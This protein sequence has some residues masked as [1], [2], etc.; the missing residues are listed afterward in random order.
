MHHPAVRTFPPGRTSRIVFAAIIVVLA[1]GLGAAWSYVAQRQ[2]A[3]A[4]T[5]N[6]I[7]EVDR[8]GAVF[9][10]VRARTQ[11]S[12]RAQCRLLVED[13]RLKSTLAT[14][15]MD[16]ATVA[17]ILGDLGKQRGS[18]F[19][20]VLNPEGH[21]FAEWGADELRGL[22]LS[23]SAVIKNAK[24]ASEAVTGSWVIG[25]TIIDLGAMTIRLD[26]QVIAFL[27]VGQQVDAELAKTL[28][29]A[30]GDG[31]AVVVG[32]EVTLL[33]DPA[34]RPVVE[35]LARDSGTFG[36][37]PVD[38]AHVGAMLDLEETAQSHPRLAVVRPLEPTAQQFALLGWLLWLPPVLVLIALMLAMSRRT[39]WTAG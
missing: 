22:D 27:V 24:G 29:A 5:G 4:I 30:T 1:V 10:L 17:D 18:G 23:A 9:H 36:G 34:L 31:I 15:G 6:A 37:R 33:S 3:T 19:V 11:E 8:A 35:T 26:G 12:L 38:A 25:K 21:V 28:A 39:S 20:M 7:T 32:G 2:L 14:E 13:P 16:E